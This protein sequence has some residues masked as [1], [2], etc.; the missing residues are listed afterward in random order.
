L[1]A[2]NPEPPAS[3]RPP[4]RDRKDSSDSRQFGLALELPFLLVSAIVVGGAF[5]YF[6]DRWLGTKPVFLIILGGVGFY[7]GVR[8]LLRRLG[9]DGDG[10]S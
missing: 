2:E 10:S 3:G 5:G 4:R 7:A 1:A 6:L 9:K 8:D